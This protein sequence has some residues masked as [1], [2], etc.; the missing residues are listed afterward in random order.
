[1]QLFQKLRAPFLGFEADEDEV[2]GHKDGAFHQ[3]AVDTATQRPASVFVGA[4][5]D[6]S[7]LTEE[8]FTAECLYVDSNAVANFDGSHG[9]ADFFNDAYHFMPDGD[10]LHCLGY[11]A[12]FDVQIG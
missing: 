5:V 7:I 3:H 2:I 12:M 8:A 1:M 6:V 10:S 4:V 11:T 9:R